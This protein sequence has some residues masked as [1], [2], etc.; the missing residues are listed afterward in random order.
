MAEEKADIGFST[1][2]QEDRP[3]E[4]KAWIW[5][6]TEAAE[7]NIPAYVD[8]KPV[9]MLNMN[10]IQAP[11]LRR[12]FIPATVK[13]IRFFPSVMGSFEEFTAEVDPENPWL[14][15]DSKA[16][17]T[18]DKSELVLYTA[19]KEKTYTVP[20][21]VRVLGR[22]SFGGCDN[23]LEEVILPEGLEKI[24]E[25]AFYSGN[26]E[27]IYLPDS[28]K[29]I[30]EYA[31]YT[32]GSPILDIRLSKDLEAIKESAFST[33]RCIKEL[34]IHS[35][36][37]EIGQYA[38][39][40]KVNSIKAD[41][42]NE[43]FAAKDGILYSKDS[44]E[45]FF[46]ALEV[47]GK[48]VIP[49]GV[50]V[51]GDSV[52]S[53]NDKITEV[54]L[55]ASLHTIKNDAFQY[56]FSLQK[57][58]LENVK[59]IGSSAFNSTAITEAKVCAP[60][61]C[62]FGGCSKLEKLTLKNTKT[63]GDFAFSGCDSLKELTLPDTLEI[64]EMEAFSN[65]PINRIK[66]PES[67]TKIGDFACEAELVEIYDTERSPVSRG[68]AFSGKDHLLIVRSPKDD[69]IKFAVPVYKHGSL[70]NFRYTSDDIIM[71]LFNGTTAAY[72][73]TLYDLLFQKTNN[74]KNIQGKLMA[75][76][77]RLKYP[78]DLSREARKM[79]ISYINEHIEDILAEE[80]EK[81][82]ISQWLKDLKENKD[83]YIIEVGEDENTG[84][85][86]KLASKENEER[87]EY[88][89]YRKE[90]DGLMR[91]AKDRNKVAQFRAGLYYSLGWGTEKDPEK[92]AEMMQRSAEQGLPRA[93]FYL[94]TY[95]ENGDGV[96]QS[97]EKAFEWY[98]KAAEQEDWDACNS[99]GI[100][101]VTGTCVEADT[102]KAFELFTRAAENGS[103]S[104]MR[105]LARCYEEGIGVEKDEEKSR[106]WRE[107]ADR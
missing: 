68:R 55:P 48:V 24:G 69:K 89:L 1:G 74:N 29:I 70:E 22:C 107:K 57:I 67:V 77:Y 62:C 90:L 54:V 104:G 86:S 50:E 78:I 13:E 20:D 101:Y 9:T 83:T 95:Y 11:K 65:M 93:Q 59:K 64:I 79:Y 23:L 81:T 12:L 105:N 31:F 39:P 80:Q 97:D 45:I 6:Q 87:L 7:I 5:M 71:L 14:T 2:E 28:V 49:E 61:I 34:Y 85:E 94:A 18:K 30:D 27:K 8:G 19:R 10:A 32:V 3:E 37:K 56:C 35:K 92:A 63:I 33:V 103:I 72:D 47:S 66:I 40:R 43:V 58:N 4:L 96:E 82:D 21:G 91:D 75:A 36:L 44:K 16:I 42:D 15:S 51:I 41:D 60:Y 106:Q 25:Y 26:I 52:F 98:S 46:A 53:R 88:I 76:Y 73:Y 102:N 100:F 38:F 84:E 17:F 99:L